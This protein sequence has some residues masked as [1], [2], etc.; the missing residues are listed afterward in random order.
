MKILIV[1]DSRSMRMIVKRALRQAGLEEHEIA[2]ASNGAEALTAIRAAAPD[3]V[4]SDWNMPEM[5]GIELLT[6]LRAEGRRV[7]FGFVTSEGT[8]EMQAR[9]KEAGASFLVT[10]PFTAEIMQQVL[11]PLMRKFAS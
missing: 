10:K 6:N 8:P 2:E 3:L 7:A 11:Q 5:S 4:M 9:A 1:D